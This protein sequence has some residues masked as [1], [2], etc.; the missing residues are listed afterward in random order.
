MQS[1]KP[2]VLHVPAPMRKRF[3]A[4]PGK[5]DRQILHP[6]PMPLCSTSLALSGVGFAKN[7]G[8]HLLGKFW[9]FD[10]KESFSL[11]K[12]IKFYSL[13]GDG[14]HKTKGPCAGTKGFRAPEVMTDKLQFMF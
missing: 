4:S 3:A 12:L 2:G 10:L 13:A 5:W 9:N 14:K 6:T 1:P 8:K 11:V 7:K